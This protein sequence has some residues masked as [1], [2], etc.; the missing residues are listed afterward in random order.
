MLFARGPRP[1]LA[2]PD[3]P[4]KAFRASLRRRSI[5]SASRTFSCNSSISLASSTSKIKAHQ[6]YFTQAVSWELMG[7]L[8]CFESTSFTGLSRVYC[9]AYRKGPRCRSTGLG[10][11]N[12]LPRAHASASCVIEGT[13]GYAVIRGA[14]TRR[15]SISNLNTRARLGSSSRYTLPLLLA[16]FF[17]HPFYKKSPILFWRVD[18][19]VHE[20]GIHRVHGRLETLIP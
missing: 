19:L 12:P 5:S 4:F 3:L 9:S 8:K 13:T 18:T 11:Q 14:N 16:L 6:K 1:A 2:V 7:G 20:K 15:S 10:S 17:L